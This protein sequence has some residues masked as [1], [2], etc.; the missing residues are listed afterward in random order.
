MKRLLLGFFLIVS[1]A[2][3]DGPQLN[4]MDFSCHELKTTVQNYG[5]ALIYGK[6]GVAARQFNVFVNGSCG[7]DQNEKKAVFKTKDAKNCHVGMWCKD[8]LIIEFEVS[9]DV[10]YSSGSSVYDGGGSSNWGG[11]DSS[12]GGSLNSG[13]SAPRGPSYNPPSSGTRGSRYCPGC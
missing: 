8:R 6:R 10:G 4:A 5:H 12:S 7:E 2:Q 3:A 13:S 1:N 11:G 9:G